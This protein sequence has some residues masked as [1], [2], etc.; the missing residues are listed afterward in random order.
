MNIPFFVKFKNKEDESIVRR[1][2]IKMIMFGE[3]K[4]EKK[5]RQPKKQN[6]K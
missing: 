2:E 6:R 1:M 5:K 3:I 4:L